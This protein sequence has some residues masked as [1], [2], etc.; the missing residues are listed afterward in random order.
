MELLKKDPTE[1]H[2]KATMDLGSAF[3]GFIIQASVLFALFYVSYLPFKDPTSAV[4]IYHILFLVALNMVCYYFMLHPAITRNLNSIQI[5]KSGI[6]RKT[7]FSKRFYPAS[8]I[9]KVLPY[10]TLI[11][12]KRGTENAHIVEIFADLTDGSRVNVFYMENKYWGDKDE[13]IYSDFV[14]T[15]LALGYCGPE[16]F[17]E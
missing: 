14:N 7:P 1:I 13:K 15:L 3:G 5:T 2:V 8:D 9:D 4:N 17:E 6:I 10:Y 11:E 16:D 12:G